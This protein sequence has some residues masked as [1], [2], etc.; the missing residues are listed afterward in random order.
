MVEEIKTVPKRIAI[1]EELMVVARPVTAV[2]IKLCGSAL[3]LL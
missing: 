2:L 1:D 3:A